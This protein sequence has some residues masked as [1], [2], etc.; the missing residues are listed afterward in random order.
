[1]IMEFIFCRNSD[2]RT[3]RYHEPFHA[4][5]SSE[6]NTFARILQMDVTL[7]IC[8]VLPGLIW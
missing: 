6:A 1:L 8:R 4:R 2:N 3:H 7:M 5:F